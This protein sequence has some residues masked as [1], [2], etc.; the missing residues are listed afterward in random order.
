MSTQ[1]VEHFNRKSLS[2]HTSAL[3]QHRAL[4]T[5][6]E[7]GQTDQPCEPICA[8][9]KN[10]RSTAFRRSNNGIDSIFNTEASSCPRIDPS[11]MRGQDIT[12]QRVV[13][14][15]SL[16]VAGAFIPADWNMS[17]LAWWLAAWI[18]VSHPKRLTGCHPFKGHYKLRPLKNNAGEAG[19]SHSNYTL[20]VIIKAHN[21]RVA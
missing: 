3:L 21:S 14:L 15:R 1:Q 18:Q 20:C 10:S 6:T 19:N 16:V 11:I 7:L 17:A 13:Q 4:H 5:S 9:I 2:S 8:R 12:K